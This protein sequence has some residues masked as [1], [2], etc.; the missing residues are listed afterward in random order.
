ML[1]KRKNRLESLP[2]W[3]WD[4]RADNWEAGFVQLKEFVNREGHAIV[5]L[6]F[7]AANGH[8]LGLWV[9]NQRARR[10]IVSPDRRALLTSIPGW[11]WDPYAEKWESGFRHIESFA[12]TEGHIRVPQ[13]FKATDGF[14]LGS[15]VQIQRT[16]RD[17]ISG[18][19]RARLESLPGWVWNMIDAKWESGFQCLQAYAKANGNARVVIG[20]RTAEGFR[21]GQWVSVQRLNSDGI[22]VER[23]AR[24]EALSGW[25]WDPRTDAFEEG[26]R[27]VQEYIGREG[28]CRIP[29]LFKSADGYRVGSW[30]NTQRTTRNKLSPDRK[31][32][33]E[34]IPGWVW[35]AT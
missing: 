13:S 18:E 15:W 10:D 11:Q 12:Q 7:T 27:H 19:R 1:P 8:K 14:A 5:P 32:R 9:A 35:A 23:R 21:L 26:I 29:A 30:V 17:S 22:T 3:S 4:F 34:G 2:G 20:Y 31:L 28:H 24:L 16:S 6:D 33:L 25:S